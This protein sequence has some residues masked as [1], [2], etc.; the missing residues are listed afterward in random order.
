MICNFCSSFYTLA[1]SLLISILIFDL[2]IMTSSGYEN[3]VTS[4][5]ASFVEIVLSLSFFNAVKSIFL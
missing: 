2:P 4:F 5:K 3:G 1:A